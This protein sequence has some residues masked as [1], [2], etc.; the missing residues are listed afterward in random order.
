MAKN[1]S[2]NVVADDMGN[3]IRVSKNNPEYGHIRLE[4]RQVTFNTQ[5]WVQNKTRSTLIQG[6]LD[7][8]N[9]LGINEDTVLSGN[10]VILEQT[11]PFNAKD[12]ERDLKMAGDTGVTCKRLNYET[13][14]EEPIYRRTV[15][16]QTGQMQ[17]TL[18]P[19]TNS[20]EI[21]EANG[22]APA[23]KQISQS[24]LEKLTSKK[25]DK[26]QKVEEPVEEE[27]VEMEEESFEL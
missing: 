13:G 25:K 19:H 6:K 21:R 2:I 7:D 26:A 10:I 1:G 9:E 8:L 17:D 3:I 22:H 24:D 5:G 14:E 15:Y 20:N 27:V 4:Q 18:I 16:D 11:S 23:E 12:P